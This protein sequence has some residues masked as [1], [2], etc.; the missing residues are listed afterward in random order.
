MGDFGVGEGAGEGVEVGGLDCVCAR[1]DVADDVG[2][3]VYLGGY[4]VDCEVVLGV[5]GV[6]QREA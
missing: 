2:L 3:I 5:G 1:Q 4:V 6:G